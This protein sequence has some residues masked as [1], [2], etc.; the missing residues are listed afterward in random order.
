MAQFL[1]RN[2]KEKALKLLNIFA[3]SAA[4][5]IISTP[6]LAREYIV[7]MKNAGA[8][9]AVMVFEPP[10]VAAG[11]G[12]TVRFVPTD[13]GHNAAPIPGMVPDGVTLTTGMLGK[14]YVVR[15]ARP[16]FY[17]IRCTPHY[18]MGMVALI[19]AGTG[20][21]PNAAA[22]NASAARMPSM[23]RQRMAPLLAAAR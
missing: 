2:A 7:H 16:G 11:V 17:G 6:A 21:A 13:P 10:Y 4:M 18:G 23:A 3:A 15:V 9:G 20:T 1:P 8:N 22:V 19:K 14:E 12:D 5:C